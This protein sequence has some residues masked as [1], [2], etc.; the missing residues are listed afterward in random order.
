MN[1]RRLG[2]TN[3]SVSVVGF[4]TCQLRLVPERQAIDTL[5]R[6]FELGVNLVHTAPDYEGADDLVV[7]A[8]KETP[9]DVI[10]CNQGWGPIDL[11][12]RTFEDTCSKFGKERL[13][14]FGITCIE[15]REAAGD[16]LWGPGGLADF[17]LRKKE[18][19]RLGGIFCTTHKP[20]EYIKR[21]IE[22][23]IFDALMISYNLLGFH[24]LS[25]CDPPPAQSWARDTFERA[26]LRIRQEQGFESLPRNQTEVFP[27]AQQRD[28]G[29]MIMK[30]LAGGLL[31]EGK[32]FSARAPLVPESSRVGATRA[33][34]HILQHPE[35]ACVVPG[36]ASVAEAEEN[37]LAGHGVLTLSGEDV[38]EIGTRRRSLDTTLCSRCGQCVTSCS[39]DLA[40]PWLFR[41]SYISLFPGETFET[42]DEFEYFRLHPG[43]EPSCGACPDVTCSCP[44]GLDIPASLIRIHGPMLELAEQGLVPGPSALPASG[45]RGLLGRARALGNALLRRTSLAARV[46]IRDVPVRL[47]PRGSAVCRLF[48]E[49]QGRQS[50]VGG[51]R[52]GGPRTAL[53]VYVGDRLHQEVALRYEV[54]PGRRGHFTFDLLAPEVCGPHRL[55]FD[56]V[57]ETGSSGR[58]TLSL[59]TTTLVVEEMA[60]D[61]A[62]GGEE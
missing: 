16:N 19:G 57:V 47:S 59:L 14:L 5:R 33:L 12:E 39:Q 45:T 50:W 7:R 41:A 21:L 38:Q 52:P 20:P 9:A 26:V 40:I 36:T 46:V 35:V 34:R 37:A 27:L 61:A 11:F 1:Y 24:L 48:L 29:L 32:A 10:V 18:E 8:L 42:P 22:T 49:N 56:L 4:G 17:L 31:C 6:G 25:E 28:I 60:R 58:Q 13:E 44:A 23:D 53:L 62:P 15:D 55:R 3:L 54:E 30:P 2:R 51:A 43:H